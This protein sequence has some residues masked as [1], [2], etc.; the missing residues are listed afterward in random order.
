[1]MDINLANRADELF[2]S[3]E[4]YKTPKFQ[5][6]VKELRDIVQ[7]IIENERSKQEKVQYKLQYS[8]GKY[9]PYQRIAQTIS[10]SSFFVRKTTITIL[11]L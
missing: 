7:P 6:I 2:N 5:E 9:T 11:T 4:T 1:M 3:L 10:F 8:Y